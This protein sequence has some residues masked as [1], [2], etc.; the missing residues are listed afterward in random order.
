[1][2]RKRIKLNHLLK[3]LHVPPKKR[4]G[5][6]KLG[7]PQRTVKYNE[8]LAKLNAISPFP[9]GT[10]VGTHTFKEE[11]FDLAIIVAT[12]NNQDYIDKCISS[13]GYCA[14]SS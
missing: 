4:V 13:L 5:L 3:K 11:T 10:S 6:L 2:Y 7:I 1:M 9:T 8:A 14:L 12:Y